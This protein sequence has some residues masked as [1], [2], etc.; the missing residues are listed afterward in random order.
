MKE[1][2]LSDSTDAKFKN[3]QNQLRVLGVRMVVVL[4]EGM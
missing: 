3:R 1:H 4:E 2:T